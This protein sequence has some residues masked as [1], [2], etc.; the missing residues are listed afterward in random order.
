MRISEYNCKIEYLSGK[1][2][3]CADFLSRIHNELKLEA[4]SVK[5]V[6]DKPYQIN[7]LNSHKLQDRPNLEETDMETEK[8]NSQGYQESLEGKIHEEIQAIKD[9]IK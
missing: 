2:N 5:K 9:T 4:A 6:D 8:D 1:E 7:V 3:I